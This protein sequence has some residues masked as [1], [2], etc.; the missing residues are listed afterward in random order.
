MEPIFYI[1]RKTKEKL[2]E[3][4]Y[5]HRFVHL[6]YGQYPLSGLINRFFQALSKWPFVSYLYGKL[7]DTKWS[8]KKILPFIREFKINTEEFE[9][10]PEKFKSFNDFFYR[11]LKK[12]ARKIEGGAEH[13]I[14]PADGRYIFIPKISNQDGFYVKGKKFC[15]NEF[16]KDE[17][18]A[19]RYQNGVMVIG[20]LCP[21]D[22][23]RFHFPCSG[24]A[25][26]PKL[27]NGYLNSVNLVSLKNNI[28]VFSENKRMITLLNSEKFGQIVYAE[29]GAVCVGSIIQ[30]YP[31]NTLCKKGDEKGYFAF[32]GSS[33]VLLFEQN[34]IK[35][36]E[37]LLDSSHYLELKCEF[38]QV[39]GSAY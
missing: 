28:D 32:G 34:R 31:E 24:I 20:R 35:L 2:E 36:S 37:D 4:V 27:I 17:N 13:A 14:I 5:G 1:D 6:L 18:L 7:Q 8:R 10:K 21:T 12:D 22:Y 11:K 38:G 19:K 3:K 25:Q 15:L 39:L 30:T 9:K 26:K 16:L 23:H 29:V 33:I